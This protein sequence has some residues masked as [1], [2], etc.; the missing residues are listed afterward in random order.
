MLA[1]A[2]LRRG[3]LR[4]AGFQREGLGKS[5]A[6]GA[7]LGAALSVPPLFFFYKPVV[8]DTPLEYGPISRLTRRELVED[9]LVDV[10]I[11]IALLE[12][13]AFRG[14]LSRS[15][16]Q[17]YLLKRPSFGARRLSRGGTFSCN[18]HLCRREQPFQCG[19]LTKLREAIHPTFSHRWRDAY[20]RSCGTILRRIAGNREH[21]RSNPGALDSGRNNDSSVVDTA[22]S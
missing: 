20:N 2:T 22:S 21:C 16:A 8:L 13:V 5:L 9:L 11:S 14:L 1:Y 10:P 4:V 18:R 6:L 12:E 3:G 15:C 17:H 19:T 7:T